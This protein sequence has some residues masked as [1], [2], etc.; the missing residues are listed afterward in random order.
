MDKGIDRPGWDNGLGS[1]VVVWGQVSDLNIGLVPGVGLVWFGVRSR[2][3]TFYRLLQACLRFLRSFHRHAPS[4]D[5]QHPG[6]V[7]ITHRS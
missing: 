5:T 3:L 4:R 1:G 7:L 2:I 6:I